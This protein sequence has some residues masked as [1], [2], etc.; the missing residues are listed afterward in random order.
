MN[1]QEEKEHLLVGLKTL[2]SAADR[3]LEKV[4]H[5]SE[6]YRDSARYVWENQSEFDEYEAIFNK[7]LIDH[8]VDSGE[9]TKERLRQIIKMMDAP[10]FARIDFLMEGDP[11]P[12]KIYIGKFSF[13]DD[14]G[15]FEVFDWRAPISGMYYEYGYGLQASVQDKPWDSGLCTGERHQHQR[16]HIAA[17]TCKE[18]GS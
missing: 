6:S 14:K 5:Y 11:E 18:C 12:M 17:G 3:L 4:A 13:W 8:V 16:R 1:L 10:Y 7:L 15:E 2:Q 9:Q